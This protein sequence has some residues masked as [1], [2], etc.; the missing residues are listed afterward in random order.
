MMGRN[1]LSM[2]MLAGIGLLASTALYL[3]AFP[4]LRAPYLFTVLLHA[5]LGLLLTPALIAYI[6]RHVRAV[7]LR[8]DTRRSAA[9]GYLAAIL[10]VVCIGFGLSLLITGAT[11]PHALEWWLHQI[12]GWGLVAGLLLHLALLPREQRRLAWRAA[13]LRWAV[14]SAVGA[15]VLMAIVDLGVSRMDQAGVAH[16]DLPPADFSP[17][18]AATASGGLLDAEA[19]LDAEA[20]GQCHA[21]VYHEWQQSAHRFASFNNPFYRKSVEYAA[22]R[23]GHDPTKWCGGCH[24]PLLLF[25]GRMDEP[26]DVAEPASQAG[27]TCQVCHGITKINDVRGNGGYTLAPPGE[28]PFAGSR[29]PILKQTHNLLVRLKPGPHREA[30]LKPLHATPEFCSVCH[31]VHI[32]EP[33]N[34]FKWNRG[35]NEYDNWHHS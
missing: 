25:S 15:F 1:W 14:R 33:V 11:R 2:G 16:A 12:A 13:P 8:P 19:F 6:W 31:K 30:M 24:D 23:V 9:A 27:I 26:I 32:P 7:T 18:L 5:G 17:S 4:G 22:E 21:D 10:T 34:N 28:Y 20:C 3:S 35:Q 29:S